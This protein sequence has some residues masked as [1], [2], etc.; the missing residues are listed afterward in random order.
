MKFIEKLGHEIYAYVQ[1]DDQQIIA[2]LKPD[3]EIVKGSMTELFFDMQKMYF[4][5]KLTGERIPD[6]V[7]I[8]GHMGN[9][10][11]VFRRL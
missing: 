7:R 9:L 6:G 2:R 4:F 5:D 1:F 11:H 10:Y 8:T 3:S